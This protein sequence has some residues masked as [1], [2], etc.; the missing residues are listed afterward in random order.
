MT[1][2]PV[3][4]LTFWLVISLRST[5][6]CTGTALR[7]SMPKRSRT[8]GPR[9]LL[10]S[11]Y[12]NLADNYLGLGHSAKAKIVAERGIA[13]LEFLPADGYRDFVS[14]GLQRVRDNALRELAMATGHLIP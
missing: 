14:R 10:A 9:P 8:N 11:L 7:L 2:T 5:S 13:A 1:W 3:S 12:L 6:R 4:R